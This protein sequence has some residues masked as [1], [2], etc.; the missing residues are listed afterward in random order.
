MRLILSLAGSMVIFYKI[1]KKKDIEEY[2][3]CFREM[4]PPGNAQTNGKHTPEN[5]CSSTS[6]VDEDKIVIL[7]GGFATQLSCH[8]SEPVDGDP[9]WSARFLATHP[10]AVVNTHLDFL[11]GNKLFFFI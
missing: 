2:L 8:I 11:R 5:G 6:D 3:F 10:E 4:A 9:L 1:N 7:D